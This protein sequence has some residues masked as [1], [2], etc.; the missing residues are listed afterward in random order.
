MN[1]E[2][3]LEY[4][5]AKETYLNGKRELE[6]VARKYGL[7]EAKSVFVDSVISEDDG[8]LVVCSCD[9][10]YM[11]FV[12]VESTRKG[13]YVT[14]FNGDFSTFDIGTPALFYGGE[15]RHPYKFICFLNKTAKKM[16]LDNGNVL[17][18]VGAESDTEYFLVNNGFTTRLEYKRGKKLWNNAPK[19]KAM[20]QEEKLNPE[21]NKKPRT[22]PSLTV[23]ERERVNTLKRKLRGII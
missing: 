10:C 13:N 17:I 4:E 8:D 19:Y 9:N 15:G 21:R 20:Q 12:I 11:D 23:E 3:L 16:F 18:K 22:E 2:S 6:A 1:K 5:K 14:G 7:K